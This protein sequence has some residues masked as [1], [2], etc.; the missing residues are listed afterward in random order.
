VVTVVP[1]E[2]E[3]PSHAIST[4]NEKDLHAA[5]KRWYA[6]PGDRFEVPLEGSLIDIVRGDLLIEIQTRNFSAIKRKL[7]KLAAGH[8]VRLVHPIPFEKWIVRLSPDKESVLGRRKSPKRGTIE[9]VF[10]ELVHVPHLMPLPNF[11]LEVLLIQEEE[12]RCQDG[13]H[14][15]WR[16]KGWV[17]QERRLIDVVARRAFE[18]PADLLDLIP[19]TMP[20]P[21]TTADMAEAMDRPRRLAQQAA[22]ALRAMEAIEATGKRGNAVLYSRKAGLA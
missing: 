6:E 5:I 8:R 17:T 7:A 21:F 11:S 19:D 13:S 18:N 4:L 2:S 9:D 15:A 1:A 20:D 22:Y 16:R 14:R 12:V 10:S 3:N